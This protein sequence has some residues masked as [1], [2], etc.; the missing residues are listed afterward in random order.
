MFIPFFLAL[1]GA[2]VP[3]TLRE[4]LSLLAAMK[5]GLVDF[6]VEGFYFLA[7]AALVKDERHIDRFDRV[8]AETFRG[9]EAV[10]GPKDTPSPVPLPEDWLRKLLEKNLSEED[11][12]LVERLGGFDAL[13]ETLRQR[14][15]EQTERH[16]GGSKWIGTAGT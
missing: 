1:K 9:L 10:S 14:L 11:K 16:Q 13:M 4:F 5:T 15:E 12:A 2:G 8:F 6:D 7:R 3:V